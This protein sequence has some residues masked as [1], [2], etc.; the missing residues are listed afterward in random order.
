MQE[1]EVVIREILERRINIRAE[2]R[3]M[4]EDCCGQAFL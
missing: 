4:A 2:N 3:E 1:Y